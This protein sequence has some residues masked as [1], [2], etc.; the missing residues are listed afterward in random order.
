V[1]LAA[2]VLLNLRRAATGA[3]LVALLGGCGGHAVNLEKLS[4]PSDEVVWQAGKKAADDKD[5][6]SARKYLRRLIDGFPQSQHQAEA[7]ITLAD[8]YMK[9]GGVGNYVLAIS[10]YRE[11]LTLYPSHPQAAYA[12]FQVGEAYFKQVN[13]PDRDQTATR[14]ALEEYQRLLDIYPNSEYVE[15]A[16]ERVHDCRQ[17]LA[18]SEFMVGHFYQRTRKSWRSAIGR[19]QGILRDYPDFEQIDEVLFRLAESLSAAGR[20]AEA[21][22][23]LGRLL[24]EFPKSSFVED[25]R[26]LLADMPPVGTPAASPGSPAPSGPPAPAANGPAPTKPAPPATQ[27]P[28]PPD[29]KT[30]EAEPPPQV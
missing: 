1:E 27:E 8:T 5:W 20:Y 29:V 19:Y 16:R 14:Q 6:E 18:R 17:T 22:P 24:E 11:F 28:P 23:Q 4:S 7:R 25:A 10:S 26:K 30:R 13:S 15:K 9:Q 3:A 12:Q 21:R 2:E